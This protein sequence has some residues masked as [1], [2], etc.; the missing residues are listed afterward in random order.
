MASLSK[1][2]GFAEWLRE[3]QIA[4]H[5][6]HM[7]TGKEIATLRIVPGGYECDERYVLYGIYVDITLEC[8]GTSIPSGGDFI[9]TNQLRELARFLSAP[10][11]TGERVK[12][13]GEIHS[14]EF[15]WRDDGRLG[16]DGCFGQEGWGDEY[17][18][19]LFKECPFRLENRFKSSFSEASLVSTRT[20]LARLLQLVAD[21]EAGKP[22]ALPQISN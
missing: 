21:V 19:R 18:E 14:L 2:G 5:V 7:D 1:H 10:A 4:F 15:G 8:R 20:E 17:L 11:K 13:F 22:P 12:L 3:L 9:E 16:M 6:N